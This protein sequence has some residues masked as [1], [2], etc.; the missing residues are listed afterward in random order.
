MKLRR[1]VK[2]GLSIESRS[3]MTGDQLLLRPDGSPSGKVTQPP[4]ELSESDKCESDEAPNAALNDQGVTRPAATN[5]RSFV[6][7][8]PN[9][10]ASDEA[11]RTDV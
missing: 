7:E 6:T 2:E 3:P 11:G 10:S 4:R 1:R 8:G 5:Q 9:E